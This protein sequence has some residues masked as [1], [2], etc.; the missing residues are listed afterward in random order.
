MSRDLDN[1]AISWEDL[2]KDKK[3]DT[4][5]EN[6]NIFASIDGSFDDY[7]DLIYDGAY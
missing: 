2:K 3:L 5:E 1:G 4:V 6:L 7:E